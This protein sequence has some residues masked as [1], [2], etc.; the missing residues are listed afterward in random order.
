PDSLEFAFQSCV[1]QL[2]RSAASGTDER[3]GGRTLHRKTVRLLV[4]ARTLLP[5][6]PLSAQCLKFREPLS[7]ARSLTS[8]TI[9]RGGVSCR[10]A[11]AVMR[12]LEERRKS[13][14]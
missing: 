2:F 8:S 6:S 13:G 10:P 4:E 5:S 11:S 7:V 1:L 9:A 12:Q 14:T 3:T